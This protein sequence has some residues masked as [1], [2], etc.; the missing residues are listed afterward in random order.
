MTHITY[1]I[2]HSFT[3][4]HILRVLGFVTRSEQI[5]NKDYLFYKQ[6]CILE[7]THPARLFPHALSSKVVVQ[8]DKNFSSLKKTTT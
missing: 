6:L 4:S 2:V 7:K 1:G 5:Q 8:I 3:R